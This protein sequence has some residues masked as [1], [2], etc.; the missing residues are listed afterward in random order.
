MDEIARDYLELAL[1]LERHVEGFV[2]AYFGPPEI[3][4]AVDAAPPRPLGELAGQAARLL[5]AVEAE[6]GSPQR[7]EY[8]AAQV[9][10]MQ[11][12]I[13]KAAGRELDFQTEVER[14]FDIT[15]AMVDESTFA[16]AHAE[17]ERA[18]PGSGP[19][20]E[21]LEDW[22]KSQELAPDR[23]LP[24]FEL[25]LAETRRRTLD[26]FELPAGED[27]SMQV[28]RDQPWSA[29]N[30]YLG[31]YRSRIDL[32]SDL[33]L[34]ASAAVPLLAHE[35]YA[36]HHTEHAIKEQKLYREEGRAEHAVQLLLAPECVLSEGIADSAREILFDD[37]SLIAFL[38]DV[39]YPA[40]GL[41]GFDVERQILVDCAAQGLG[42]V[43]GNAALLLHR[44][45]RPVE[46]V[47]AYIEH[48]SLRTAREAL[49]TLKF[50]QN[51]LYRS[52]VFN[53]ALGK[54]LLAP[55]LR[56]ARARDNFGRL[57][58]QALTPSGVRRWIAQEQASV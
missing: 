53:Y 57:L 4:A 15:P 19:L 38:G 36:G 32:N 48:W 45:G 22:R 43:S 44:E 3:K 1:S 7:Q 17:L 26:L 52:Y 11:V 18:L 46:E 58:A 40:A 35:A 54:Q 56:G 25:A 39:L 51:R 20:R 42:G 6:D 41:P 5:A 55:L 23:V 37:E 30:W 31:N 34:R 28:V 24:V 27:L 47:Q 29:Y 13:D 16:A 2:D 14:T 9:R 21:R 49:Q 10:A 8:L 12:V 33:P 50:I